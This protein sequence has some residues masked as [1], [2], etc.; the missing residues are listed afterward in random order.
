MIILLN[1]IGIWVEI[2]G[3][4]SC[5]WVLSM[6]IL[7]KLVQ[8]LQVYENSQCTDR[9]NIRQPKPETNNKRVNIH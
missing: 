8:L 4:N 2:K 1:A 9:V 6:G 3:G 5:P 7:F